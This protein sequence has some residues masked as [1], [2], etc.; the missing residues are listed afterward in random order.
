MSPRIVIRRSEFPIISDRERGLRKS[1]GIDGNSANGRKDSPQKRASSE[2]I[3]LLKNRPEIATLNCEYK[4][5][6]SILKAIWQRPRRVRRAHWPRVFES[7]VFTET[8][9]NEPKRSNR[10]GDEW[11]TGRLHPCPS[12]AQPRSPP[13]V[14]FV[15]LQRR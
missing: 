9:R 2:R 5:H 12:N 10:L 3:S 14:A 1:R 13:N 15:L 11:A 8:V 7:V 4:M 6:S